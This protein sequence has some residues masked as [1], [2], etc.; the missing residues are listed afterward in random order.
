MSTEQVLDISELCYSYAEPSTLKKRLN[1]TQV[2]PTSDKV[3]SSIS[4]STTKP[5]MSMTTP[6]TTVSATPTTNP[7]TLSS[8]TINLPITSSSTTLSKETQSSTTK[9]SDLPMPTSSDS[10]FPIE[11]IGSF[12]F[13]K[14]HE[15]KRKRRINWI[16]R[17]YNCSTSNPPVIEELIVL[18]QKEK[19]EGK[20]CDCQ[21]STSYFEKIVKQTWNPEPL[22]RSYGQSVRIPKPVPSSWLTHMNVDVSS[23]RVLEQSLANVMSYYNKQNMVSVSAPYIVNKARNKFG[24][25]T[26]L[27]CNV[28]IYIP[29]LE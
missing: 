10:D 2:P 26:S 7:T 11:P 15:F 21:N 17:K 27:S 20:S 23:T 18:L 14:S 24:E 4:A 29:K 8:T 28:K 13:E 25:K 1:V 12:L 5:S 19:L 16:P 22:D 6:T 9:T 3:N